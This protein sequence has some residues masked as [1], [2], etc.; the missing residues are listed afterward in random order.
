M[1]SYFEARP[2]DELELGRELEEHDRARYNVAPT[3]WLFAIRDDADGVRRL[4][5][6]RW[7][8][9]P[10]WARDAS[11]AS[12]MINAR[13]ESLSERSSYR[14]LLTRH[15]CIVPI[16]GFYEWGHE[17]RPRYVHGD[18]GHPL[19]IAALWTT[20]R[21]PERRPLRSVTLLTAEAFDALATVHHRMPVALSPDDRDLWLAHEALHPDEIT[22]LVQRSRRHAAD[23]WQWHTVSRAV[24]KVGVDAPELIEASDDRAE[25]RDVGV[26]AESGE[27]GQLFAD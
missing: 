13:A 8:L 18:A 27:Q 3:S 20:W 15:R 5:L 12:K 10:H 11:G 6:L 23:H 7:G 14:P 19:E 2:V 26:Q 21:D 17:R 16:D 24:N 1:A 25:R 9:I 4:D 22:D